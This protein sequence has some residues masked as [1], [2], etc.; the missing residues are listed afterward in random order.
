MEIFHPYIISWTTTSPVSTARIRTEDVEG[1][2]DERKLTT[3]EWSSKFISSSRV[4]KIT[5]T[6]PYAYYDNR[7]MNENF[8]RSIE[9]PSNSTVREIL[10]AIKKM[11]TFSPGKSSD[12][13]AFAG[14]KKVSNGHYAAIVDS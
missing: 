5:V 7:F 6:Q 9:M 12:H 10:N 13:V 4:T 11:T 8:G 14:L 3:K 1:N 2:D